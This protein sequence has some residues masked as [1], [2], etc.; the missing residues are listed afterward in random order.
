MFSYGLSQFCIWN[1]LYYV[2]LFWGVVYPFSYRTF[3]ISN[4]RIRYA[5]IISVLLAVVLPLPGALGHLRRGLIA[6]RFPALTC[7]GRDLTYIFY[8]N[9][10]PFSILLAANT[11]MLVLIFWT[12]FKVCIVVVLMHHNTVLRVDPGIRRGGRGEFPENHTHFIKPH[13]FYITTPIIMGGACI[14]RVKFRQS[15]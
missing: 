13:P 5:H 11:C 12:I 9:I 1:T 6:I 14:T 15:M 10:L 8:A 3:K 2:F 7:V 4:N